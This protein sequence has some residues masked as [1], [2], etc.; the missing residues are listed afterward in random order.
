MSE[1]V[2]NEQLEPT[3]T[4][5]PR[6]RISELF[7]ERLVRRVLEGAGEAI[8]RKFGRV[9]EPSAGLTTAQLIE[10]LKSA[11]DSRLRN[12]GR[13]GQV[14]PHLIKLKVEWGKHEDAANPALKSLQNELHAAAIDHINDN[15]YRTLAPVKVNVESDIFT[16]TFSVEPTFGEFEAELQQQ[17]EIRRRMKAGLPPAEEND[18]Q[19]TRPKVIKVIAR[20]SRPGIESH[21]ITIDTI[22]GGRHLSVGRGADNPLRLG[23]S[24]VSKVHATLVMKADETLVL[25]DTGSTNGTFINGRRLAYGDASIVA[26]GDV[27]GFGEVE[28]RL[29]PA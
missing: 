13:K 21:E 2:E 6:R 20:I 27:L 8:D 3:D 24:S 19:D 9:E 15:R 22:P 14:A 25:A 4:T 1:P 26:A 29:R 12:E 10:R 16:K 7:P 17:D 5:P 28:V 18:N 23:H 11:I